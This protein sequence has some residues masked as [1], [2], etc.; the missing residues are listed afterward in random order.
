MYFTGLICDAIDKPF[1][2]K[3]SI[4]PGNTRFHTYLLSTDK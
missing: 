2:F 3:L 1:K 4:L